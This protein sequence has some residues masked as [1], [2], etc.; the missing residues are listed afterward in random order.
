MKQ[1]D[2]NLFVIDSFS[3]L[4]QIQYESKLK[5]HNLL[6]IVPGMLDTDADDNQFRVIATNAIREYGAQ[7]WNVIIIHNESHGIISDFS[8][9][10]VGKLFGGISRVVLDDAPEYPA[11]L[12]RHILDTRPTC[13]RTV[14]MCHSQ[15][16][17]LTTNAVNCCNRYVRESIQI[18][19]FGAA[20]WFLPKVP[21][22]HMMVF[23]AKADPIAYLFGRG[24]NRSTIRLHKTALHTI[25]NY[26][27]A[28]KLALQHLFG[29]T[30][31]EQFNEEMHNV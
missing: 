29:S 30:T 1:F 14:I 25:S 26:Q 7:D 10:L 8:E 12:L 15:G 21:R 18:L 31:D 2:G 27:V 19:F 9:C 22:E 6:I 5:Y 24:F 4:D 13:N 17:I 23:T 3:D 28:M 16:G 20:N 11:R